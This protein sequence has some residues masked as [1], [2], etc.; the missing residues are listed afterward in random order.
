VARC[1]VRRAGGGPVLATS[2]SG[3]ETADVLDEDQPATLA[4]G[5]P[6]G[7]TPP[8]SQE[9]RRRRF[10]SPPGPDEHQG[11]PL[12]GLHMDLLREYVNVDAGRPAPGQPSPEGSTPDST[13]QDSEAP[14]RG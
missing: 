6:S 1:R 14:G 4:L 12:A 8:P 13:A 2:L 5:C 7:Y 11:T 9:A 10:P 3:D